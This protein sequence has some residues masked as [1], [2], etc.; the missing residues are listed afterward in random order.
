M[1]VS[2]LI[3]CFDVARYLGEA[4]A[5]A[6]AQ[7]PAPFEIIVVDDGS[8]DGSAEVAERF[9]VRVERLRGHSG[10]P[11]ARNHGVRCASG[12]IIFFLDADIV[13]PAS[14]IE[15][16]AAL[17]DEHPEYDAAFGSYDDDPGVR[18]TLSR[19]RNLLHHYT[20][21]TGNR[22][23]TTFWTGCGLVRRAAFESVGGFDDTW[24]GVEDIELGHRLRLS[25]HRILLD[26]TLQVKHLK[27][28]TLSSMVWTDLRY[29]AF[30]W[31]RLLLSEKALPDDLNVRTTQRV[32]VVLS[33]LVI[34]LLPLLLL[35]ARWLVAIATSAA[36]MVAINR[37]FYAL[38]SRRGG[39]A[40]ALACIPLHI[41][42]FVCAGLGFAIALLERRVLR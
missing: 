6:L 20:H 19:F 8:T 12:D 31:S 21:Q 5:S 10:A 34:G 11:A 15:R 28:W 38:L 35:D 17:L 40:F 23:A 37:G 36:A 27:R 13:A 16:A 29:R 2:V 41:V 39:L 3:P 18:T 24:R 14:A 25:G 42:Y 22:E 4:L 32:S 26:P 30:L 1:R 33:L 9:G 7:V